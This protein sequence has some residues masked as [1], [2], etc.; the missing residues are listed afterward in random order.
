M[1]TRIRYSQKTKNYIPS[2]K[3]PL[4]KKV[5]LCASAGGRFPE[6]QSP[7]WLISSLSSRRKMRFMAGLGNCFVLIRCML[8]ATTTKLPCFPTLQDALPRHFA[9]TASQV[10]RSSTRPMSGCRDSA[11]SSCSTSARKCGRFSPP[12]PQVSEEVSP[13]TTNCSMLTSKATTATKWRPSFR[14]KPSTASRNKAHIVA[15]A[16]QRSLNLRMP[17]VHNCSTNRQMLSSPTDL[18]SIL[19]RKVRNWRRNAR[20][21]VAA[22]STLPKHSR[23]KRMQTTR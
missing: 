19:C 15:I 23:E 14:W 1:N 8:T 10:A 2:G 13:A 18:N 12:T 16:S 5:C 17:N 22:S 11:C 6:I 21:H 20:L 4:L 7:F 3:R 9:S